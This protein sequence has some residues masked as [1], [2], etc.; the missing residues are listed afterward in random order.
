MTT[1]HHHGTL[2]PP[3]VP[4][5]PPPKLPVNLT[6]TSSAGNKTDT[7]NSALSLTNSILVPTLPGQ[8]TSMPKLKHHRHSGA[9]SSHKS[10]KSQSSDTKFRQLYQIRRNNGDVLSQDFLKNI[11]SKQSSS[12]QL[13]TNTVGSNFIDSNSFELRSASLS[14][15]DK[16]KTKQ[17]KQKKTSK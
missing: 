3:P 16:K 13:N 11:Q 1:S 17:S 10:D 9:T 12:S 15:D 4:T 2:L 7:I 8:L 6:L 14:T 5:L